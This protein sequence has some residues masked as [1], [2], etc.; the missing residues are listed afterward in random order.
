MNDT[1][2]PIEREVRTAL[3]CAEAATWTTNELV[4]R[5]LETAVSGKEAAT[6]L[7]HAYSAQV[8]VARVLD[9]AKEGAHA[10]DH[11]SSN[12][13]PPRL[14]DWLNWMRRARNHAEQLC[15][16]YPA[17]EGAGGV[18]PRIAEWAQRWPH[19]YLEAKS[20]AEKSLKTIEGAIEAIRR[21][22]QIEESG[23]S[24]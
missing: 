19:D 16:C 4:G 24:D 21:R 2:H 6:T 15:R 22:Q 7:H 8:H 17:S 3:E 11:A 12:S 10:D 9:W 18:A 5:T 1:Q 14:D 13:S 20:R 23:N